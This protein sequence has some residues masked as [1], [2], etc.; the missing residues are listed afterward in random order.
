MVVSKDSWEHFGGVKEIGA[1]TM[2]EW[3]MVFI[4]VP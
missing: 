4:R 1:S 3:I 2:H